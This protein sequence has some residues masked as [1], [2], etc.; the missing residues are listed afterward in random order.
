MWW[1]LETLPSRMISGG[2]GGD[3]DELLSH[4]VNT[5]TLPSRGTLITNLYS[6][7]SFQI[8][9]LNH[10]NNPRRCVLLQSLCFE[11]VEAGTWRLWLT[12]QRHMTGKQADPAFVHRQLDS[13]SWCFTLMP[14]PVSHPV[15]LQANDQG[16][17]KLETGVIQFTTCW[18]I[19]LLV[20]KKKNTFKKKR[21]RQNTNLKLNSW[22]LYLIHV[23]S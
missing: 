23:T 17:G 14:H 9:L 7:V 3:G 21:E 12:F 4:L 16:H 8:V 10:P 2:W 18:Q 13:R 6:E 22:N 11:D 5:A 15:T 20:R 1:R 19:E